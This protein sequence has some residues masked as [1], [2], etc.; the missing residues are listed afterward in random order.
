MGGAG[1]ITVEFC[2]EERYSKYT[3]GIGMPIVKSFLSLMLT[4]V[5]AATLAA[6]EVGDSGANP[7]VSQK[8]LTPGNEIDELVFGRLQRLA[9]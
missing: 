2:V 8:R 3:S 4:F 6:T 9:I 1:Q 7:F 5:Y